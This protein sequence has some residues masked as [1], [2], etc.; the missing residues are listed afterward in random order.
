MFKR[1]QDKTKA[2]TLIELLVVIVIIALLMAIA[3]PAYLSQQKKAK[4]SKTQQYLVTAY[5]SA[6]AELVSNGGS[7]G[8]PSANSIS[9][10]LRQDQPQITFK[11]GASTLASS[12]NPDDIIIGTN[13][14]SNTLYLYAKSASGDKYRLVGN[15]SGTGAG[16]A[17][18]STFNPPAGYGA[19]VLADSPIALWHLDEVAGPTAADSI[20]T[21]NG[22]DINAPTVGAASLLPNASGK[23]VTLNGTTQ[24]V[25]VPYS[26]SY[27]PTGSITFEAWAKASGGQ[28]TYR[29]V[30]G[31]QNTV[32]G[33][34]GFQLYFKDTNQILCRVYG[35]PAGNFNIDALSNS[36]ITLGTTYHVVCVWDG[37]AK[38]LK[39]YVNGV[40]Q[41]ST[42]SGDATN[43]YV[44]Q[45][46]KRMTIG[47]GDNDAANP[48][49]LFPGTI[50]EV[51]IYGS[52]LSQAQ[53]TAHWNAAQ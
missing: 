28:G 21:N 37:V 18:P 27:N 29:G 41:T 15:Q 46:A 13:S 9:T 23:S 3:I 39:Q 47:A 40:L 53:V 11:V 7:T 10:L 48:S 6:R 5:K 19:V 43:F 49:F 36:A 16:N 35:N 32:P 30:I 8:Y 12:A 42:G 25:S 50:D 52:A 51:A 38:T 22:T 34:G 14:T 4:A 45:S 26:A 2:F 44:P 24:Y 1:F 31:D 33:Q 17:N 20:G